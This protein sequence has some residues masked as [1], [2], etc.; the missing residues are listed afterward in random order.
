[1]SVPPSTCVDTGN[2]EF[3]RKYIRDLVGKISRI[4]MNNI[5]FL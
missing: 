5:F 3:G 2:L 4:K 1:M